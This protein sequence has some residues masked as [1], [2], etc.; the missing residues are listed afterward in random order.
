M[1]SSP[2]PTAVLEV[3]L[4]TVCTAQGAGTVPP[5]L[6]V[7]CSGPTKPERG[8]KPPSMLRPSP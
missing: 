5:F 3:T 1:P 6:P 4:R 7:H 8:W 2:T